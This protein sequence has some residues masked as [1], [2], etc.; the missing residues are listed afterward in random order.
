MDEIVKVVTAVCPQL[1]VR[2]PTLADIVPERRT[3]IHCS[4]QEL[5]YIPFLGRC[6]C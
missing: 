1:L 6:A 4:T 2:E 3:G 5:K